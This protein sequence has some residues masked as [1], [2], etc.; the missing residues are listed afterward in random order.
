V[1]APDELWTVAR[2]LGDLLN[3][4]VFVGGMI[5]ELLVT[6]EAASDARPTQDVDCVVNLPT[7][8]AYVDFFSRLRS[9]GFAE[10]MDEGAP[11]CRWVVDGVRVDV[12]PIDP[13]IFGFSNVWYMSAVE[14]STRANGPDGPIRIVDA[15]HYCATKIESF[16]AR[17]EGDWLHHDLE[18]V[19]AIV[20]GR[21]ELEGEIAAAPKDVRE[22]IAGEFGGWLADETFLEALYGHFRG[23]TV[24]QARCSIVQ[25]RIRRIAAFSGRAPVAP[26]RAQPGP[27]RPTRTPRPLP[28]RSVAPT[29]LPQ[30]VPD[31]VSLR[32]T[33]IDTVAYDS[34]TQVLTIKFRKGRT[35]RYG[36]V[37]RTVYTGLLTAA[38]HGR[39][40]NQWIKGRYTRL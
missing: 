27:K 5:R 17:G 30:G 21:P 1:K 15:P 8:A 3:E 11:I 33:L 37:P 2:S 24:S 38:S 29:R 31:R 19:V 13:A 7:R 14:H 12:M 18:D 32:S 34:P 39:Y 36:A 26:P 22:F 35:Y 28:Q 23:D 20:D 10:C 4:V 6:D 25:D 40:Y 9:R 16:L